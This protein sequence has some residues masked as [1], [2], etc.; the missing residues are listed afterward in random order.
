MAK[1]KPVT[2]KLDA[3]V[4]ATHPG[5]RFAN[6]LPERVKPYTQFRREFIPGAIATLWLRSFDEKKETFFLIEVEC[7]LLRATTN[8]FYFED[9]D[10]HK[11]VKPWWS[12][13]NYEIEGQ[14][15]IITAAPGGDNQL[16][17]EQGSGDS[18]G[19]AGSGGT[20]GKAEESADI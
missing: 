18:S 10:G 15:P 17:D 12:V 6:T 8:C 3:T 20:D 19:P 4:K 5:S 7:V 16:E 2:T 1:K 11:K 9:E 13:Y 14:E